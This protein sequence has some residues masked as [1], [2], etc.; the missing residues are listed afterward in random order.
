MSDLTISV[1]WLAEWPAD[2]VPYLL[3]WADAAFFRPRFVQF[4][5]ETPRWEGDRHRPI[6][7][8]PGSPVCGGTL[9]QS[10]GLCLLLGL[11]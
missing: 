5:D 9:F 6:N 11:R 10:P 4:A 1:D 3:F 8:A 2:D 7:A